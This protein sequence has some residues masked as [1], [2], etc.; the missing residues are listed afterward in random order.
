MSAYGEGWYGF[1][2][3]HYAGASCGNYKLTLCDGGGDCGP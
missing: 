3:I 1:H 2:V